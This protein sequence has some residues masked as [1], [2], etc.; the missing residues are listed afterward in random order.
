M[1]ILDTYTLDRTSVKEIK[2]TNRLLN[3]LI[4]AVDTLSMNIG[5]L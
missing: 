3:K 5:R 4:K 1:G 2:E